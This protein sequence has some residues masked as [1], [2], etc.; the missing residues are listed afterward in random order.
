M[1]TPS[2]TLTAAAFVSLT[3]AACGTQLKTLPIQPALSAAP[4]AMTTTG[5]ADIAIYFSTQPHAE[6]ARRVG[7]ASHSVRIAR[8]TDGPDVSCNKALADAVGKLRADARSKGANAVIN[9]S[10]RFHENESK[11]ATEYTCGV[12]PSA[13]AIAVKGDLVVLQA[14]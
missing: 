2:L 14:Q 5:N 7:E 13:A 11:S 4:A 12:S 9:V 6:V 10:T 3:L 8:S 1:R